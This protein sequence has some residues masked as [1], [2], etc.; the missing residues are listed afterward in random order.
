VLVADD[1]EVVVVVVVVGVADTVELDE[2][3]VE[4]DVMDEVLV[5]TV[6]AEL[7]TITVPTMVVG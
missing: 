1:V 6:A 4:D 7:L 3:L 5:V 2:E